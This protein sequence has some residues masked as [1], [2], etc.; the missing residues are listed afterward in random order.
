MPGLIDDS[1][2]LA[3][4]EYATKTRAAIEHRTGG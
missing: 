3:L 4:V 1:I 2:G